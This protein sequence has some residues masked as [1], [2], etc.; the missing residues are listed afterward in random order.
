MGINALLAGILCMSLPET[1]LQ[2]TLETVD[3]EPPEEE[4][5]QMVGTANAWPSYSQCQRKY[6]KLHFCL[7]LEKK[8][9]RV[10]EP[11]NSVVSTPA[12]KLC[13]CFSAILPGLESRPLIYFITVCSTAFSLGTTV[14][15]PLYQLFTHRFGYC[16]TSKYQDHY[17]LNNIV[18][19]IYLIIVTVYIWQVKF[20][21]LQ[22]SDL[23]RSV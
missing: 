13:V 2:P 16:C 8:Y 7:L 4:L 5:S 3:K 6:L 9:Y 10:K 18:S 12:M 23:F 21:L 1:K 17:T 11:L 22:I 15:Q 20:I 19:F 14:M